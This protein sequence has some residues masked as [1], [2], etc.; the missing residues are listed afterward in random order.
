MPIITAEQRRLLLV[1]SA[2]MVNV[3]AVA[4]QLYSSPFYWKQP[5]HTSKLSG[6]EWVR[7]LINGHPDRIWTELGVRVLST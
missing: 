2:Y 1:A 6:E 4:M 5:Y 3:V 7:E